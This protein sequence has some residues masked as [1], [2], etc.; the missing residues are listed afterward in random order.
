[1]IDIFTWTVKP[2]CNFKFDL[3]IEIWFWYRTK[4]YSTRASAEN[5]PGGRATEKR[6]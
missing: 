3:M 6:L 1:M 2:R 5:F 4:L